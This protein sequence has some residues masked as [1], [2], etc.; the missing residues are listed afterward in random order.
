MSIQE[1]AEVNSVDISE[2]KIGHVDLY[3]QDIYCRNLNV[4]NPAPEAG[5]ILCGMILPYYIFTELQ[6]VSPAGYGVCNGATYASVSYIGVDI[7]SPDLRNNFLRGGN[8]TGTVYSTPEYTGSNDT[9]LVAGNI[10][11]LQFNCQASSAYSSPGINVQANTGTD[12]LQPTQPMYVG[13]SSPASFSN[14]PSSV[15]CVYIIKL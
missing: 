4:L 6:P 5:L 15:S 10:P 14:V 12:S 11:R 1:Y 8:I 9:T 7:V 2:S 3:A 13:N